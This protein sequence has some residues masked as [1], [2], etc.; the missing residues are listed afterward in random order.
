MRLAR[1]RRDVVRGND[2]LRI[3]RFLGNRRATTVRGY[4]PVRLDF[5]L[6]AHRTHQRPL[7][8]FFTLICIFFPFL[9]KKKKLCLYHCTKQI[10]HLSKVMNIKQLSLGVHTGLSILKPRVSKHDSFCMPNK[11]FRLLLLSSNSFNYMKCS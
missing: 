11:V 10:S 5:R 4:T 8:A 6:L 3:V 7:G 9:C 1:D 2:P